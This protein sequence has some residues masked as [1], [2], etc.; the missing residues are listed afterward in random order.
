[1]QLIP[2]LAHPPQSW[3]NLYYFLYYA[4]PKRCFLLL[5]YWVSR[6]AVAV[7]GDRGRQLGGPW[8]KGLPVAAHP[9][10]KCTLQPDTPP[11]LGY[12]PTGEKETAAGEKRESGQERTVPRPLPLWDS[13]LGA[14]ETERGGKERGSEEKGREERVEEKK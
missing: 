14:G 2:K 1:M 9:G 4:H 13:S 8:H 7:C 5:L 11:A 10:P 3:P 12:S 6:C